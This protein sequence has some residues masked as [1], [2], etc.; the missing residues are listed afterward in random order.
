MRK[1][2]PIN[3]E[4]VSHIWIATVPF[5]ISLYMRK[6]LFI[7]INVGQVWKPF[8]LRSC[9]WLANRNVRF[10]HFF[11]Q[12]SSLLGGAGGRS[13]VHL[14]GVPVP[15]VHLRQLHLQE[16][17]GGG[18][19]G[20][21]DGQEDGAPLLKYRFI[22]SIIRCIGIFPFWFSHIFIVIVIS[23]IDWDQ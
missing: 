14:H 20:H 1:Y 11:R 8:R 12:F 19:P 15:G 16:P 4:A 3:E 21:E 5:L 10:A 23:V 2:F 9:F 6:I 17:A 7:F 18:P 13:G 22:Y